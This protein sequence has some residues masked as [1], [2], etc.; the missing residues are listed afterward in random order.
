MR[1]LCCLLLA[2]VAAT[3]CGDVARTLRQAVILDE[4][5]VYPVILK[6]I[7][8]SHVSGISSLLGDRSAV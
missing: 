1:V 6:P 5:L 7:D 3:S 8:A 2:L 4:H